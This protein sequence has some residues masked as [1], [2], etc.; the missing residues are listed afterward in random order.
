MGGGGV[1]EGTELQGHPV[2]AGASVHPEHHLHIK[3][4]ESLTIYYNRSM[5]YF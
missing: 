4:I 5:F 1:G 3:N 2:M